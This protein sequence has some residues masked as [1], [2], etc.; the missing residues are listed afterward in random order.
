MGL[1][2]VNRIYIIEYSENILNCLDVNIYKHIM[3]MKKFEGYSLNG[4]F[5]LCGG[6]DLNY[7]IAKEKAISECVE[8]YIMNLEKKD[9]F[10]KK[11]LYIES[12]NYINDFNAKKYCKVINLLNNKE[13]FIPSQMVNFSLEEN[14]YYP[15]SSNGF[16]AHLDKEKVIES[17][18]NECAER[19]ITLMNWIS[20]STKNYRLIPEHSLSGNTQKIVDMIKSKGG[21]VSIFYIKNRYRINCINTFIKYKDYILFGAA[22]N[23][24]FSD[25]ILKSIYEAVSNLNAETYMNGS[26]KQDDIYIKRVFEILSNKVFLEERDF[27]KRSNVLGR[28]LKD[29]INVFY[30]DFTT[31]ETKRNYKREVGRIIIPE[32]IYYYNQNTAF[33]KSMM[34]RGDINSL[35]NQRILTPY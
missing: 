11:E 4:N 16:S 24:S 33:I 1:N 21:D 25:S 13:T 31:E 3:Q 5:L 32:F 34:E 17:G 9:V 6:I 14:N 19:H 23:S 12:P 20:D 22:V 35:F 15:I 7:K 8:R 29:N 18:V 26:I 10:D 30:T 27:I 2:S 28:L